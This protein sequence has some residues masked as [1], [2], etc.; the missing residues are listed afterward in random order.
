[1]ESGFSRPPAKHRAG[2]VRSASRKRA[3]TLLGWSATGMLVRNV[4]RFSFNLYTFE[5]KKGIRLAAEK[6]D[7]C[8]HIPCVCIPPK[9]EKYCSPT[10]EEAGSEET[11]ICLRLRASSLRSVK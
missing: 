5:I 10:G 9:G 1:M 7:K 11:E 8:A 6:L 3:A 2:S 4:G